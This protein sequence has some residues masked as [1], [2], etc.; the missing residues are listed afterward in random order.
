MSYLKTA[1]ALTLAI[2]AGFSMVVAAAPQT[3]R[4]TARRNAPK[5][6]YSPRISETVPVEL[7]SL[8]LGADIIVQATVRPLKSYLSPDEREL[9][10]D[11]LVTPTRIFSQRIPLTSAVPGPPSSVVLTRWGGTAIVEGVQVTLVDVNT[12]PLEEGVEYILFLRRDKQG[13]GTFRDVHEVAGTWSVTNGTVRLLA[14]AEAYGSTFARLR[15]ISIGKLES[16][17]SSPRP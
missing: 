16:E 10:T 4:E 7:E 8:T 14:K 3:I 15:G 1:T 5:A 11:Y 9:F 13:K 6:V 2:C 17:L 12:P